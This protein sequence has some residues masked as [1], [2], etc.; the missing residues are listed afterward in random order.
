MSGGAGWA[1]AAQGAASILGGFIAG[2]QNRRAQRRS[3]RNNLHLAQFAYEK[4]LDMWNRMNEYNTPE[5]QMARLREANLNPNMAYGK[6]TV[7]NTSGQM[8]KFQAPTVDYKPN[9]RIDIPNIIGMYQDFSLKKAQI[10]NIK[11]QTSVTEQRANNEM[12]N[13]EI[14][15]STSGIKGLKLEQMEAMSPFQMDMTKTKVKQEKQKLENLL[16]QQNL[17][18]AQQRSINKDVEFKKHRNELAKHGIYSSDNVLF[19]M[20]IELKNALNLSLP[21]LLKGMTP[22]KFKV[23]M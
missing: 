6:G 2:N 14:L 17:S 19:R 22:A 10:N 15:K 23:K 11:A 20:L 7:A 4:D 1:A 8:P 21:E 16:E 9:P 3:F 5:A 13:N 12:I 18:K